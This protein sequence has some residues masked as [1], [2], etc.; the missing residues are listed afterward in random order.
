MF[1]TRL[2]IRNAAPPVELST[3]EMALAS[4]GGNYEGI[5]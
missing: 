1:K 2:A 4:G 5:P 3:D